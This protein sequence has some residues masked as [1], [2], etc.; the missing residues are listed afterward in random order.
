MGDIKAT[1]PAQKSN[2]ELLH[3]CLYEHG[4]VKLR[5]QVQVKHRKKYVDLRN[6][7]VDLQVRSPGAVHDVVD[8]II[9]AL[10][11]K[12]SSRV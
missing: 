6:V 12:A 11:P 9:G 5:V 1:P 2:E 10:T 8:L 4:H 3:D 7:L